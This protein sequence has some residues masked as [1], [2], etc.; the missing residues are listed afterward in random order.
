[1][2]GTEG[3]GGRRRPRR[4]FRLAVLSFSVALVVGQA[5]GVVWAG[6][7][8]AAPGKG[9]GKGK[10]AAADA[11][12]IASTQIDAFQ[13]LLAGKDP[14]ADPSWTSG[15]LCGNTTD[16]YHELDNVPHRILFKDLQA[17]EQY[18]IIVLV[19]ARDN[20]G[21]PGYDGVNSV[22]GFAN[23]SGVAVVQNAD[24]TDGCG[25]ST[26]CQ[27][28]TLTFSPSDPNAQIRFNAHLDLDAPLFGGSSLS[29]RLLDVG[30]R[31]VPLPVKRILFQA[32]LGPVGIHIDK[33]GPPLVHVGNTITYTL[34]V[35]LTSS[36][37]LTNISVT[38]PVCDMGPTLVS[39]R[40]G[41]QDDTLEPG[42]TWNFRCKHTVTATD[43]DPV[44]NT[45]TVSG[46][47]SEGRQATDKDSH[48]VDLIHPAIHI[49]KTPTPTFVTPGQTI[50]YTYVT[51]NKGDTSL[52]DVDVT[53]DKLGHICTIPHPLEPSDSFTCTAT[54][55]VPLR[56]GP[57]D[58]VGTAVGHDVLGRSVRDRDKVSVTVI[59][60]AT[61]TPPPTPTRTPPSGLAFTGAARVVPMV[62]LALVLL[63]SGTGI[64]FLTRRRNG[65]SGA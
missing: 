12:P 14:S 61:V 62:G 19:D 44:P 31:N 16:C 18:A 60:G 29:A 2:R 1:M 52:Y 41:D 64:L 20:A 43:P 63:L 7:A 45:A 11:T 25:T 10:G 17:G 46:T 22:V 26:T 56:T 27:S 4:G 42:E 57:V 6:A 48:V 35:T 3:I 33:G 5:L 24:T 58:N 51:R 36:E 54:F 47:S 13:G 28:F 59:L 21:H 55:H 53:D 9:H 8:A 50:T 39:K 30:A 34:A 49:V 32:P 40:G 37:P 65:G 15:N 38:D 23:V